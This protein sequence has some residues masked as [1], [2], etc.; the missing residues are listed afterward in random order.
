[1]NVIKYKLQAVGLND[2]CETQVKIN[3]LDKLKSERIINW[4]CLRL[5]TDSLVG[6]NVYVS[7]HKSAGT[8]NHPLS[9][10][11]SQEFFWMLF[12]K[13]GVNK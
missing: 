1:M 13:F 11:S 12:N 8:M 9:T 6:K 10:S 2:W 5:T 3:N 4:V 7:V